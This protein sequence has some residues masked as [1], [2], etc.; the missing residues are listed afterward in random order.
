MMTKLINLL[1]PGY[2]KHKKEKKDNLNYQKPDVH[3]GNDTAI[4]SSNKE[5]LTETNNITTIKIPDL[6]F[7][8]NSVVT[9][10]KVKEN[11]WVKKGDILCEVDNG[12]FR[13]EFESFVDGKIIWTCDLDKSL[14]IDSVICKIQA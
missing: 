3:R 7:K 9:K 6:G 2:S 12:K 14:P 1:F 8:Q 10:W 4:D 11:D 13:M 5:S